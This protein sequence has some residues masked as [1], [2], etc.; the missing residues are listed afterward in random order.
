MFEDRNDAAKQLVERLDRYRDQHPLIL[1]VPRGA[2][3]MGKT[4]AEALG[5]DL[6]VVLVKKLCAPDNPELAVGSIDDSGQVYLKPDVWDTCTAAYINGEKRRQ[7]KLLH[8]RREQYG[9][10]GPDTEVAGRI[11]IVLDDGVATGSTMVSALRAVRARHP[12]RLIAAAGV[13]SAE[14]QYLL[15]A[16]ADEVTCAEAAPLL[17]TVSS[18]FRHFPQVSDEEVAGI[19]AAWRARQR[20]RDLLI[21]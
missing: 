10:G 11:V 12:A 15:H 7:L 8:L 21:A 9:A 2:V 14:A 6:D 18:H 20:R 16:E 1:A 5:G 17:F 4:I 19:L 3:P 13:M